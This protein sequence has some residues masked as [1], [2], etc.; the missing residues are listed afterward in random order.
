MIELY[1]GLHRIIQRNRH[2]IWRKLIQKDNRS[3]EDPDVLEAINLQLNFE[4]KIKENTSL[5]EEI[6]KGK[7][8]KL[9][10]SNFAK[11]N[12]LLIKDY[13]ISNLK[14][15]DI[16]SEEIIKRIFE[17][18][19][20]EVNLITDGQ[21]NKNFLVLSIKTDFKKLDKNSNEFEKY[22]AKA[23]L[24]LVNEIYKTF[25]ESLN[26]K[27]KVELNQRTIDRV[28]NSF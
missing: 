22:E 4:T 3:I 25:D 5:I 7:F 21:F 10:L 23:R 20:G 8:D 6:S 1:L 26:K 16:F 14:Q 28:K 11:E 9:K 19:D 2:P 17:I 24:N 12:N 27:Y 13:K 18:K 15:N